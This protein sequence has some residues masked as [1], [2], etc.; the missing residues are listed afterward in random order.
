[1]NGT[2]LKMP[3]EGSSLK[4]FYNRTCTN[5]GMTRI[6]RT[7][8]PLSDNFFRKSDI[9]ALANMKTLNLGPKNRA[10]LKK[11]LIEYG[12]LCRVAYPDGYMTN[13]EDMNPENLK[14]L[15]H[16]GE[17]I[18]TFLHRSAADVVNNIPFPAS[19]IFNLNVEEM[20]KNGTL[21]NFLVDI[22]WSVQGE[23]NSIF[24]Q[25]ESEISHEKRVMFWKRFM[26]KAPILAAA[27]IMLVQGAFVWAGITVAAYL[28]PRKILH[29]V[30]KVTKSVIEGN[31]ARVNYLKGHF[32]GKISDAVHDARGDDDSYY[33]REFCRISTAPSIKELHT[34]RGSD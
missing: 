27:G 8:D 25:R 1:M 16:C 2:K 19:V 4:R 12:E 15:G 26:I 5:L 23:A 9:E 6:M 33:R 13:R 32:A 22:H 29:D 10:E 20:A 17:T 11:A 28:V 24:N 18:V 3:K 30:R 34:M 21:R 7:W 31:L 14:K